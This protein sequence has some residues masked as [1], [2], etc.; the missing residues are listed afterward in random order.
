MQVQHLPRRAGGDGQKPAR[1]AASVGAMSLS[2]DLLEIPVAGGAVPIHVCAPD[3][4]A[5]LPVLVTVPSIFGPADDLLT[6]MRSLSLLGTTAVVDPFWRLS[7]GGGAVDYADHDGAIGRLSDFDR[8]QCRDDLSAV[9]AWARAN[10]NGKVVG[11]GIC[12]GG[13]WVLLGAAKNELDAVITWHGSRMEGVLDRVGELMCPM[14]LHFGDADPIT[15]PEA[16]EAIR[17]AFASN[18]DCQ[19]V[20]HAGAEH[21][22]S[23]EGHAWDATAAEAGMDAVRG[24]LISLAD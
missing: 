21:G 14:R 20:V 4:A 16:I 22:F 17:Q 19:I 18:P 24:V 5:E 7:S 23:H 11:L 10:G 6:Q 9:F 13:P 15:P 2:T 3:N 12:F 1:L 8:A